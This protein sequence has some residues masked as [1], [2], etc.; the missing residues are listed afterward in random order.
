[1]LTMTLP[2]DLELRVRAEAERRGTTTEA[3][4]LDCVRRQF[5]MTMPSIS[6]PKTGTA[7]DTFAKYLGS[8]SGSSEA[9]SQNCGEKFTDGLVED[10]QK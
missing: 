9:F 1:M 4:V 2:D 3:V 10:R 8:V 5:V 6:E 7:Y